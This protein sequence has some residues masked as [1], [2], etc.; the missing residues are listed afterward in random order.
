MK[1]LRPGEEVVCPICKSEFIEEVT[2][3]TSDDIAHFI[4]Y[5]MNIEERKHGGNGRH[6][7]DRTSQPSSAVRITLIT[8]TT[9]ADGRT[10]FRRITA[11]P[12][13]PEGGIE[14]GHQNPQRSDI[15]RIPLDF[16]VSSLRPARLLTLDDIITL[17]LLDAGNQ[18]APPAS[19]E[20]IAGLEGADVS[21]T[22]TK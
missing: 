21:R 9:T 20:A 15:L 12:V 4:P 14:S 11:V 5:G 18:G 10:V 1:L 19:D 13:Q 2:P 3:E 22:H 16:D 7:S 8:Q 6:D 17:S